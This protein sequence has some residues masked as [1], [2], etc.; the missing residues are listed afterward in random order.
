MS[1]FNN[2]TVESVLKSS[3]VEPPLVDKR[4]MDILGAHVEA[5][6]RQL[7]Q[8]AKKIARHG[9]RKKIRSS[10]VAL[11]LRIQGLKPVLGFASKSKARFIKIGQD[12]REKFKSRLM[13]LA[14]EIKTRKEIRSHA[15]PI[16]SSGN[17]CDRSSSNSI[18]RSGFGTSGGICLFE[19]IGSLPINYAFRPIET[20]SCPR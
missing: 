16:A 15:P 18:I 1:F 14:R 10:D 12:S 7:I 11:A 20:E 9:N 17:S 8:E 4:A 2:D 13:E 5:R 3:M 6:M 19:K